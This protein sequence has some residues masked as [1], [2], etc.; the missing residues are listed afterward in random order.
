MAGLNSQSYFDDAYICDGTTGDDPSHPNNDFL[1]D[2]R[3]VAIFPDAIGT[4][5]QWT[6]TSGD[7]YTCVDETT[8]NDDSDYVAT[9]GIGNI[10]TYNFE[11]LPV[12]SGTVLAIQCNSYARKDDAGS[13]SIGNAIY[14]NSILYSGSEQSVGDTYRYYPEIFEVNPNTNVRWTISELNSVEIGPKLEE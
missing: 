5:S 13:R 12:S 4:Y 10:D 14:Y 8:P 7:N 3:I 2:V 6:P 11:S 9:S 1:G